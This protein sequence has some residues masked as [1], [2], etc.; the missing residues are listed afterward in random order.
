MQNSDRWFAEA[1]SAWA[2]MTRRDALQ[3]AACGF[4]GLALAAMLGTRA[5]GAENPLAAKAPR[6]EPK[7]KRVIFI[8]MQG[9]PSHVDTFDYKPA[10]A[11]Q[12]GKQLS[13]AD[14]RVLANTGQ[15]QSTH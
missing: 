13:F 9:G 6:L 10:L 5:R 11:A 15:S 7:A 8:F 1:R 12:D 2:P 4:G 3:H 14:A